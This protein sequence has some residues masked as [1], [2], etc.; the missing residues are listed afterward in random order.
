MN[1][2]PKAMPTKHLHRRALLVAGLGS[3][4]LPRLALASPQAEALLRQGGVV[5]AFRHALAPGTFDPPGFT[6]GQCSTQRNLNDQGK[7]QAQAIGAWFKQRQLQPVQVRTSPWC[8]CMDTAQLAFG[9][10]DAWHALGSPVGYPE[11]AGAEHLQ[12]LRAALAAASQNSTGFEVWVTHMFVL[13]DLVQISVNS[14]E[15]LVLKANG[16]G[17]PEAMARLVIA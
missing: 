2:S 11:T 16:V 4:A 3:L 5:V 7:A 10:A 8:R 12:L 17:K 9:K 6:L 1:L 13:A 15:G 14:G